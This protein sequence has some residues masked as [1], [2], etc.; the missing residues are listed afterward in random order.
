M[1]SGLYLFDLAFA[2][3]DPPRKRFGKRLSALPVGAET[4][5]MEQ[6]QGTSRSRLIRRRWPHGR[7]RRGSNPKSNLNVALRR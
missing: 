2:E 3:Q 4:K 6:R 5:T 1:V 7:K